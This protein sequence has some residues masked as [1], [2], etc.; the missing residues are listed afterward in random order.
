[1]VFIEKLKI[2]VFSSLQ[3]IELR[4]WNLLPGF[5]AVV[6]YIA[7]HI[8]TY[9]VGIRVNFRCIF[10]SAENAHIFTSAVH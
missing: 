4:I 3:S 7:N 10:T 9:L 5:M 2:I 8:F 6:V 1:M